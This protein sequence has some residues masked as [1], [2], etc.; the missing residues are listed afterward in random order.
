MD[1]A[2]QGVHPHSGHQ[3][4]I[5]PQT[6]RTYL[7]G[8]GRLHLAKQGEIYGLTTSAGRIDRATA[9]STSITA[10]VSL[11]G[12]VELVDRSTDG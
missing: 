3:Q 11:P 6:T 2:T 4:L 1:D 5:R 8:V 7:R 9:D 10:T 12:H